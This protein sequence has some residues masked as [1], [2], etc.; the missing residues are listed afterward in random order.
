MVYI[1]PLNKEEED[2]GSDSMSVLGGEG[3]DSVCVL[4]KDQWI[5]FYVNTVD[6]F[7]NHTPTT[8]DPHLP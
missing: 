5:T 1:R 7:P 3:R 4:Q 2:E 6:A 8:I